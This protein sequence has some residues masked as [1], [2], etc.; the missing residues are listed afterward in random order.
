MRSIVL[1]VFVFFIWSCEGNPI[2]SE[3]P[4]SINL[5]VS[6]IEF[7]EVETELVSLVHPE[8][9]DGIQL[10]EG[11]MEVLVQAGDGYYTPS[12]VGVDNGQF[13]VQPSSRKVNFSKGPVV[14]TITNLNAPYQEVTYEV[15]VIFKSDNI[16]NDG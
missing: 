11:Q 6:G 15:K 3:K 4:N 13:A 12:L 8:L 9:L 16:D 1:L 14:F 2:V 7:T 10:S 5:L